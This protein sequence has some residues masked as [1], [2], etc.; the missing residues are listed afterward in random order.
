MKLSA[1]LAVP[2]Q[3][4]STG[5]RIGGAFTLLALVLFTIVGLLSGEQARRNSEQEAGATLNQLANRLMLS[6]DTGM[7]ERFREVQNLAAVGALINTEIGATE[8]RALIDRLQST[9]PYYSWVGVTDA[10][11]VVIAGTGGLLE[12]QDASQR[13]WFA[14][15]KQQPFVGDVHEARMLAALLPKR[16]DGEPI[17][18]VDFSTPLLTGDR[19]TG[20]LGAHLS[21]GWAEERYRE[22]LSSV[23]SARGI[24]IKVIGANRERLL[25]DVPFDLADLTPQALAAL[26]EQPAMVIKRNGERYLYSVAHS[27]PYQTYPG[28][29]WH[30]L[31]RQPVETALAEAVFLQQRIWAFGILGAAL[32]GLAG[33]WLARRLTAPLRAVA[34]RAERVSAD[35]APSEHRSR[36][37][38][39]Q[40]ASSIDTL[41]GQLQRRDR[42]LSGLSESIDARVDQ[43]TLSLRERNEDLQSFG[44]NVSHDLKGPIGSMGMVLRHVV[45]EEGPHLGDAPR[46]LLS[47]VS[48]ECER[49][50][51]LIDELMALSMIEQRPLLAQPVSMGALVEQVVAGLRASPTGAKVEVQVD[52]LPD[53]QGDEALLRQVWQNLI[54]NA[55]KYS[56]KSP[57]PQVRISAAPAGDEVVFTVKDNG[58]GFDMARADRLFVVFQRLH[59]ASE[60][61]GTGVGLSIVKRV[62][63]RHRGRVGARSAPGEGA[64]FFFALPV[65]DRAAWPQPPSAISNR[66]PSP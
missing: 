60:F 27:R 53:V 31:V 9:Y 11:G 13:P 46:R 17:R 39:T 28:L 20:V 62:V 16:A 34:E 1:S 63:Q 19:I 14:K 56:S 35:L 18:L 40:L 64:E 33:A 38:V 54:A 57:Q 61:Q 36:D 5:L 58:V 41:V 21:W 8:W 4:R 66:S 43:Q 25:G 49:L 52:E 12:G 47:A 51:T 59:R 44:R 7:Y 32:F 29:G 48:R 50:T 65:A 37:E 42:E 3:W 26:A 55:F 22:V 2:V 24:E 15:G 45:Q 23:D 30:V 10:Q 6:L